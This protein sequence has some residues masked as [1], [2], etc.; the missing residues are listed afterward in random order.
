MLTLCE[1][2]E[3]ALVYCAL[4]LELAG[5]IGDS[6]TVAQTYDTMATIALAQG[7]YEEAI[8]QAEEAAALHRERERCR[9]P[10]VPWRSRV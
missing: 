3:E 6:D 9:M 5:S 10:P 4:S 7:R 8:N 1:E 2:Y